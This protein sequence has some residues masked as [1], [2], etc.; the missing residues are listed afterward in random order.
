MPLIIRSIS[1]GGEKHPAD[2]KRTIVVPVSRLPLKDAA[3]V[4]KFK[5]LA[6]SRWTPEP[7]SDSGV[8]ID[9]DSREN[10][11]FKISCE[12]FPKAAMNLKWASDA[13]DRLLTEANV[14]PAGCPSTVEHT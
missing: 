13:L 14:S 12:D 5:L 10:G 4:H 7:P 6:G 3:A 11:Y 1:Y 2:V 9:E 8:G